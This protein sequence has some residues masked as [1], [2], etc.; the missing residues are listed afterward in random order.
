M[1]D[2]RDTLALLLLH[3]TNSQYGASGINIGRSRISVCSEAIFKLGFFI[4]N[5]EENDYE[6]TKRLAKESVA[7]AQGRLL[8]FTKNT[9][10]LYQVSDYTLMLLIFRRLR[11]C[12]WMGRR[13]RGDEHYPLEWYNNIMEACRLLGV[14]NELP[15]FDL[16][17]LQLQAEDR[18]AEK[19]RIER[20]LE[21]GLRLR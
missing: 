6:K 16:R 9:K 13:K 12:Y 15:L 8:P 3:F 1:R 20:E 14:T 18:D 19:I 4:P 11:S 5:W 21:F 17:S 10:I 2:Y 7:I